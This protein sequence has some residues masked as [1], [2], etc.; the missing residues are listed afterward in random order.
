MSKKDTDRFQWLHI[1]R[2]TVLFIYEKSTRLKCTAC[3]SKMDSHNFSNVRILTIKGFG[4]IFVAPHVAGS[5]WTKEKHEMVD[6]Y[7]WYICSLSIRSLSIWKTGM[8]KSL[9]MGE[10]IHASNLTYG[11]SIN[12]EAFHYKIC[13]FQSLQRRL[14]ICTFQKSQNNIYI[15]HKLSSHFTF[16]SHT[17][18]V[19]LLQRIY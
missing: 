16:N 15:L 6:R 1:V 7:C 10:D 11:F 8:K 9:Y 2:N 14:R 5:V 3:T 17:D 12:S 18:F 19:G 13:V 4:L